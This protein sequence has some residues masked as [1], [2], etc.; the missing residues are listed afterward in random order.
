MTEDAEIEFGLV[1]AESDVAAESRAIEHAGGKVRGHATKYEPEPDELDDLADSQ[2]DPF[3]L[4]P[5]SLALGYLIKNISSVWLD[6]KRAGGQ[7]VDALKHPV[8]IRRMPYV[9]RGKLVIITKEGVKVFSAK[10]RIEGE[11]VLASV[12]ANAKPA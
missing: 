3:L 9:D 8:Q 7:L 6:H 2:F 4:I 10:E 1:V 11:K 12:L 5:A